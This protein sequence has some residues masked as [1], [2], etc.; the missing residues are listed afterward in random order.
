MILA[1]GKLGISKK[2]IF[3]D[4]YPEEIV[5]ILRLAEEEMKRYYGDWY[6]AE[7]DEVEGD[8]FFAF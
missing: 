1:M 2:A 5:E 3:E 8:A 6:D 4:Y 7:P